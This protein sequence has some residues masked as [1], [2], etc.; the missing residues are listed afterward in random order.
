MDRIIKYNNTKKDKSDYELFMNWFISIYISNIK[1]FLP[2][3]T[4][5]INNFISY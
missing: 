1:K 4:K 2:N 5:L 3:E